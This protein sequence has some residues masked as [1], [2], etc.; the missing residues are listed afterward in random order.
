MPIYHRPDNK[1][2]I[3]FDPGL[4]ISP[5][6]LYRRLRDKQALLL[7][8]VRRE[9]SEVTLVGAVQLPDGDWEPPEGDVV[10][11]DEEGTEAVQHVQRLQQA[12][13]E[14]I[15]ALFGG[16]QLYAFALDPNVVEGDTFL[17][18]SNIP[19]E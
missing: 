4:E 9:P 17:I 2:V 12:G 8:D 18:R 1:P 15:R 16:L 14:Q 19:V 3:E 13:H 10:L 7:I 6:V 11:F 5:F